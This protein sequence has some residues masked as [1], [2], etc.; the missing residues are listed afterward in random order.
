MRPGQPGRIRSAADLCGFIPCF[1]APATRSGFA[2][3][4]RLRQR[5]L[6]SVFMASRSEQAHPLLE[7]TGLTKSFLGQ[8][9]LDSVDF[10]LRPGEIHAL[11]GENGAGKSWI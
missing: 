2:A 11:L 10:T 1:E 3:W 6:G 7:V 8:R 5:P 9:A 4:A